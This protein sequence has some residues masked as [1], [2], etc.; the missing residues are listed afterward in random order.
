ML[1]SFSKILILYCFLLSVLS[2]KAQNETTALRG[3][4]TTLNI[5]FLYLNYNSP[6]ST[7]KRLDINYYPSFSVFKLSKDLNF[8]HLGLENISYKNSSNSANDST[9]TLISGGQDFD[10][11]IRTKYQFDYVFLKNIESKFKPVFGISINPFFHRTG[12]NPI[13]P[14]FFPTVNTNFGCSIQIIPGLQKI[15]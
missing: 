4:E 12:N 8:H 15:N 6:Q 7:Y 5:Y 13:L 14:T 9:G 3:I 10:F 1:S 11:Y 2:S